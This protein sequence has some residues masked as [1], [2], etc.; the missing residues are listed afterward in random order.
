MRAWKLTERPLWASEALF[1]T[2]MVAAGVWA[3]RADEWHPAALV[4]L[5]IVLAFGGEWFTVEALTGFVSASLA[6]MTLAMGLLGPLPAAICG[7]AT[8]GLHSAVARR[9]PD[10]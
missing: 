10:G 9:S 8:V 3:A 5:L 4:A 1:L 7:L 6:V 2:G